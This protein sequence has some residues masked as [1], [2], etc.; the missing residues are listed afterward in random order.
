VDWAAWQPGILPG[1]PVGPQ[2]ATSH[3]EV[4]QTTYGHPAKRKRI[5]RE[6]K[7]DRDKEEEREGGSG[8]GVES[9][10]LISVP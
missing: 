3:V 10:G 8:M 7:G 1:G 2:S 9:Q 5:G 4:G 6:E